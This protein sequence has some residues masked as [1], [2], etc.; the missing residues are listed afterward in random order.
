MKILGMLGLGKNPGA[1]LMENGRLVACAE[2]ERFNRE[3]VSMD[4]WPVESIRY[5][6]KAGDCSLPEIDRVAIAWGLDKY[7]DYMQS[8]FRAQEHT[9][10]RKGEAFRETEAAIVRRYAPEVYVADLTRAL[11]LAR[12]GHLDPAKVEHYSHH[13]CHA[14]A[15]F[16]PSGFEEALLFIL[17]GSGEDEATT[18]WRADADGLRCVERFRLPDS[19]GRAYATITEY[20][21]F[22]A[23]SDEG[24][25]MGLA[26]Y[27]RPDPD[28]MA[29]MGR[30]VAIEDDGSYAV[31]PDFIYYGRHSYNP[32]F[33]DQL[34]DLLGPPR[35]PRQ[36]NEPI[37][38]RYRNVAYAIQ[39]LLERAVVRLVQRWVRETGIATICLG[40]GVAMNCK[41]N[42][43]VAD[44]HEVERLFIHPASHDGGAGIGAA[45]LAMQ[46][47]APETV[48]EPLDS[49][50]YGPAYSR[51]QIRDL[52]RYAKL[53]FRELDDVAPLVAEHVAAGKV[54]A[55]FQGRMEMGARALGNRSILA[56][57]LLPDTKAR[58]N[59]Q[60]KH[61]EDWR[62]F[63]PSLLSEYAGDYFN[64]LMHPW[65][66]LVAAH[67]RNEDADQ[68]PSAVH[69]DGTARPQL[70]SRDTAPVFWSVIEHFRRLTGVPVVI[71]TSFNVMGEPI[72][73]RPEE[74]L[75]CFY[76]TG[77]DTLV[78]ENLVL[79]KALD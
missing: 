49:A 34:V 39:S 79:T 6:L 31:D 66:M 47:A 53:P 23:Y 20:L 32:R 8:F 69:V 11:Q 33:T 7:P 3:K 37:D 54:V 16:Y 18:V 14:A 61:R 21:G 76:S 24:K 52:L 56:S 55:L 77:I 40:G 29:A 57:P 46:A 71:N 10:P 25:V 2:E 67:V 4:R 73:N 17:D 42:G 78:L 45:I 64:Q 58:L 65:Y 38:G 44:L 13:L 9:Y 36:R 50:Y 15:A 74:A 27:G 26:P 72:I 70:V 62:P 1:C 35:V 41:M 59:D 48:F 5:C 22:R 28:V 30:F 19:L 12:L 68:I 75:R 43:I 60:V 63:C 51:D